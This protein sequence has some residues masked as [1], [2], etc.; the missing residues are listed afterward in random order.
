MIIGQRNLFCKQKKR[1]NLKFESIKFQNYTS[2][3]FTNQLLTKQKFIFVFD[4]TLTQFETIS[5][6]VCL[7]VYIDDQSWPTASWFTSCNT[8]YHWRL[9]C[10][11]H[12]HIQTHQCANARMHGHDTRHPTRC[13]RLCMQ[14]VR[15]HIRKSIFVV[16]VI[17]R[18]HAGT[19]AH[20][21]FIT[22]YV[23]S[24]AHLCIIVLKRENH[25]HRIKMGWQF[26][27][28]LLTKVKTR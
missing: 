1:K 11:C 19:R 5:I 25:H 18:P 28:H 21:I 16:G 13:F 15:P 8:I 24:C 2:I 23:L 20:I 10:K 3:H 9:R 17:V 12:P 22:F 27:W 6:N 14:W 4:C 7:C 26:E